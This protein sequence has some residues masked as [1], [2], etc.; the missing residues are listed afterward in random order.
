MT[1]TQL[2]CRA[3]FAT[4]S[5]QFVSIAEYDLRR[6]TTQLVVFMGVM[7]IG[8]VWN[9]VLISCVFA[10]ESPSAVVSFVVRQIDSDSGK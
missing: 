9:F 3:C 6:E 5:L 7:E 1:A 2:Q 10:S 8:L 4:Q